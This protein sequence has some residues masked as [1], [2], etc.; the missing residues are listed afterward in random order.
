M[1]EKIREE[2]KRRFREYAEGQMDYISILSEMGF[3]KSEAVEFMKMCALQDI[4][5][6]LSADGCLC[7]LLGDISDLSDT[8]SE[9]TVDTDMGGCLRIIGEISAY[10][11]N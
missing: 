3:S 2:S 5:T 10:N 8:L 9:C 4:A 7:G 6:C 1:E 11:A